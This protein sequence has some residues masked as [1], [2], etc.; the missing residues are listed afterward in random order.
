MTVKFTPD[1]GMIS[2]EAHLKNKDGDNITL[3]IEVKDNGIGISAE[4]Q[5]G[6]FNMFE[7]ADGGNTR[8]HG[9]IGLGLALS[10]RIIEMMGGTITIESELNEGAK[11]IIT[12]ELLEQNRNS[13]V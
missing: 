2:L 1:S 6:L 8:K 12:C 3:Q 5:Q 4:Q 10:K 13:I 9:G 11:F 7:Q